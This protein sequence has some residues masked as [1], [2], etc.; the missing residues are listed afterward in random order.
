MPQEGQGMRRLATAHIAAATLAVLMGLLAGCEGGRSASRADASL[1][2][3]EEEIQVGRAAAPYVETLAG[4]RLEN[5]PVE[6]YVRTIGERVAQ[7]TPRHD[8][9]YRFAVLDSADVRGYALP[10]GS[11]YL[12]RGLLAKL[13]TESQLAAALA[14]QLAHI[15][16]RHVVPALCRE[17]GRGELLDA[18]AAAES[19]GA[20]TAA[21]Q[22]S[23]T[24]ARL[25]KV[26]H[27]QPYDPDTEAAADRLGLDYLVAAGYNPS[28]MV[29]F[30][31]V[32]ARS[33]RPGDAAAPNADPGSRARRVRKIIDRKYQDRGGRVADEE[34]R[35]EVLDR[36]QQPAVP[37]R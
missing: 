36:L 18:V 32:L 3:V 6:A 26:I 22:Q 16:A 30:L 2:T 37:A 34:Y 7:S 15:N 27:E 12:T 13:V 14:H 5:L 8:L 20:G 11:V 29:T 10:G 4:G 28:G 21:P 33:A 31:E 23:E 25:A 19:A 17:C 35:S 1:L 9:P 24:L